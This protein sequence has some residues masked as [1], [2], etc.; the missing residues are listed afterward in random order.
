MMTTSISYH[1][2]AH[3]CIPV[4]TDGQSTH[5]VCIGEFPVR[6]RHG[7]SSAL[8]PVL[9]PGPARVSGWARGEGENKEVVPPQGLNE[10]HRQQRRRGPFTYEYVVRNE[11]RCCSS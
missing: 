9:M 4:F 1:G 3:R 2:I 5:I 10:D 7:V 11:R 6:R 8:F